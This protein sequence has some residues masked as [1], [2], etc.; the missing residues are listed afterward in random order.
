MLVWD[1]L[2]PDERIKIYDKGAEVLTQEGLYGVQASYRTGDMTTPALPNDEALQSEA[3]YF[4]ECIRDGVRP[5]NDGRAGL[6]VVKLLE[7]T[8]RSLKAGGALIEL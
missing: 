6:R 3:A 1:D 5:F 4:V 7:A 8:D 2:N